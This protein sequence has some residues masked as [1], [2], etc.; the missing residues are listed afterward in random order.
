MNQTIL[1]GTLIWYFFICPR[2]VWL[3]RHQLNPDQENRLI[4]VGKY[5]SEY[6]YPRESKEVILDGCKFDVLSSE[7]ERLVVAEVKKS[8]AHL[9]SAIMQLAYY[10]SVLEK[11]GLKVKGE[12]RIP[13][14]KKKIE[15]SLSEEIREE[16]DR[17]RKEIQEILSHEQPPPPKK[18]KYCRN[19]GYFEFC[20]A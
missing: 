12:V 17:A 10:L 8:S 2:Q 16:L 6:S 18:C 7:K 14:E 13:M 11:R 20:W 1:G 4:E 15:V 9:K 19:C 3:I 5:L